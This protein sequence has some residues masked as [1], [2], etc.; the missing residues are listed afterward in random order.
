MKDRFSTTCDVRRLHCFALFASLVFVFTGGCGK[1]SEDI[2][3]AKTAADGAKTATEIKE[4]APDR[5]HPVVK[6]DTSE[7]EIVVRLDAR[8]S[9]GTVRNFLDY[10]GEGFYDNTL[11]HFVEP[12][13]MIVAGGYAADRTL[14]PTRQSIRN[15]A[16]NGWKN[17]RGTLAMARDGSRIDS[18][19]S[20]FF[21]NLVDSPQRDYKADS[22]EEYGYCVFGEVTE[23]L[24]V[25][26][27]ISKAPTT[28]EG[29][30]LVQTPSPP[31]LIKSI[32]VV[33]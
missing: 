29:N 16:H 4:M 8:R 32:R 24:E 5:H 33:N 7:G 30:D 18:A 14:K 10:V 3:A 25:V 15:E 31:I 17:K 23:G 22:A 12:S 20:Q 28:N 9:P 11:I 26:D 19:T 27:R 2:V 21:I 1:S 6:L 13:Q